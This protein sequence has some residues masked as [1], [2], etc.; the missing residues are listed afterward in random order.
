MDLGLRGKV[1]VITGGSEGIGKAAALS[2][3]AEGAKVVICARRA[4]TLEQAAAEIRAAT[5]G[6][7]LAIPTDVTQPDQVKR[8]FAKTLETTPALRRRIPLRRQ[9]QKFGK[10]IFS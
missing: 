5:G 4:E 2:L 1:A 9:P 10:P 7:A 6:E 8:L 3:A